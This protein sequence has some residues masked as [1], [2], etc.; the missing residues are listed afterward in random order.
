MA[1]AAL[2]WTIIAVQR[3]GYHLD[4]QSFIRLGFGK[5]QPQAFAW[6]IHGLNSK[7]KLSC[8]LSVNNI[9]VLICMCSLPCCTI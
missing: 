4:L 3:E 5:V 6:V 1:S 7:V 8:A 2:S 9:V